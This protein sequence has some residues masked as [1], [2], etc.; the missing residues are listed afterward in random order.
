MT[1]INTNAQANR[2]SGLA[3]GMN[4]NQTI[5]NLLQIERRRLEPVENRKERTQIELDSF[6]QVKTVLEDLEGILGTLASN[7]L[8]EGKIVETSN[9]EVVTATATAGAAPGNHTL[10]VERLALNHQ[11]S[12]QGYETNDQIVGMG[13]FI[14]AG[15]VIVDIQALDAGDGVIERHRGVIERRVMGG[16]N[17]AELVGV[18]DGLAE[19]AHGAV[20]GREVFDESRP[21]QN[22]ARPQARRHP[23]RSL[24]PASVLKCTRSHS[25]WPSKIETIPRQLCWPMV[26]R[27]YT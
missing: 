13:R 6:D 21:A 11:I 22:H 18:A 14:G 4:T 15:D 5:Q 10:I 9:E 16:E 7:N 24:Q 20:I 27:L 19:P 12:S 1:E 23:P 2:V 8:W 3:S 17:G 25:V 26:R